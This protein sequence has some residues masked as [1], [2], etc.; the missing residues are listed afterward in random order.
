ME[1]YLMLMLI[2]GFFV[3]QQM[4]KTKDWVRKIISTFLISYGFMILLLLPSFVKSLNIL[5]ITKMLSVMVATILLGFW[6]M[7]IKPKELYA[8]LKR[9]RN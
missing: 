3:V 9:M 2:V 5:V 7:G 1:K 6:V 4:S 8:K